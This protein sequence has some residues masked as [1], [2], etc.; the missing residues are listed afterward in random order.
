V[1]ADRRLDLVEEQ[2][3]PIF[4]DPPDGEAVSVESDDVLEADAV[5][6]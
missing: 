1:I 6:L 2:A 3:G 4:R 5:A